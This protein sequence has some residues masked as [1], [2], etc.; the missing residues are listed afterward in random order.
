MAEKSAWGHRRGPFALVLALFHTL[1]AIPRARAIKYRQENQEA[2][3][4]FFSQIGE[5]YVVHHLWGRL[6]TLQGP[7]ASPLSPL[8]LFIGSANTLV[9]FWSSRSSRERYYL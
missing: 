5:L 4:G 2:V 6:G 3:G 7:S 8:S 1:L 9:P